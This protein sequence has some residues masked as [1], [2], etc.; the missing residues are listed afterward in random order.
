[1][2]VGA[3]SPLGSLGFQGALCAPGSLPI[4]VHFDLWLAPRLGRSPNPLARSTGLVRSLLWARSASR[5]RSDVVARSS[6]LVR[7]SF[8]GSLPRFGALSLFGLAHL[9]WCL[10]LETG[11]LQVHGALRGLGSLCILW[12]A[13]ALGLARAF[14]VPS[15]PLARSLLLALSLSWARSDDFGALCQ[16]GSLSDFGALLAAG[17]AP[18]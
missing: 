13:L 10:S 8:Q 17:L 3:L 15:T 18:L 16:S 6:I 9:F 5:V 11:S 4:L 2:F 12:C 14:L 7:L 1:M